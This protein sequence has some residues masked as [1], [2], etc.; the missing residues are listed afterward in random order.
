M[1]MHYLCQKLIKIVNHIPESPS[2]VNLKT[3]HIFFGDSEKHVSLQMILILAAITFLAVGLYWS[4]IDLA[5]N[6]LNSYLEG[7]IK[8]FFTLS[9]AFWLNKFIL[10]K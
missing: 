7:W 10:C 6:L 4:S 9:K 8:S 5:C 3:C 2:M 1:G